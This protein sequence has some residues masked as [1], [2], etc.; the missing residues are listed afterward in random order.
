[1]KWNTYT[2]NYYFIWIVRT[3]DLSGTPPKF[4]HRVSCH[5]S[6][7]HDH[8]TV[9]YVFDCTSNL[10]VHTRAVF[11]SKSSC[12][13][14]AAYKNRS[15]NTEFAADVL[16]S[17]V[18]AAAVAR[19]VILDDIVGFYSLISAACLADFEFGGPYI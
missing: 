19:S 4:L 6:R 10:C 12:K 16:G 8:D 17:T 14:K 7:T 9:L 3:F 13:L 11:C 18:A 5:H 15:V 1:M 2:S